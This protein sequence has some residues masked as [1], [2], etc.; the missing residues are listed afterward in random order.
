[1]LESV[2][3]VWDELR[4]GAAAELDPMQQLEGQWS[5]R[6]VYACAVG[7]QVQVT[8]HGGAAPY[9]GQIGAAHSDGT[10]EVI[11]NAG[12]DQ[13]ECDLVRSHINVQL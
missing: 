4:P 6:E 13:H 3:S 7:Q 11:G 10:Y 12:V 8:R 9:R 1:M 2:C 5:T